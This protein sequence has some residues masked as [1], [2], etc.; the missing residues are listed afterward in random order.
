VAAD[1]ANRYP[2]NILISSYYVPTIRAIVELNRGNTAAAF[3]LLQ[4][5]APYEAQFCMDAVYA[6]GQAYLASRKGNAAV[7]EFQKILDHRGLMNVCPLVSLAHLGLARARALSGDSTG[8]R[9][10]YQDFFGLWKDADP[11]IPI[12]KE[13]RAEYDKLK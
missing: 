11:D 3:D 2:K 8:A 12:L 5:A 13:A 1:L 4:T 9:T 7:A 6:R 10:A